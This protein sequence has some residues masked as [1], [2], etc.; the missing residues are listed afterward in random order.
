MPEAVLSDN[1]DLLIIDKNILFIA[2]SIENAVLC[3]KEIMIAKFNCNTDVCQ[4]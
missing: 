1:L 3:V 2:K 4:G